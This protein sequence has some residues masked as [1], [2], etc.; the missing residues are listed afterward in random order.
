MQ[1]HIV[2]INVHACS[3]FPSFYPQSYISIYSLLVEAKL[4]VW[5]AYLFP[6]VYKMIGIGAWDSRLVP[7]IQE[8]D[9][10]S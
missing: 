7:W 8:Y 6:I 2:F 9:G 3:V 1:I 4:P 10:D 5:W